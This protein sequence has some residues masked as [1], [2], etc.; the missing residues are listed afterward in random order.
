MGCITYSKL[1]NIKSSILIAY[2]ICAI[3]LLKRGTTVSLPYKKKFIDFIEKVQ[4]NST[5][6]VA[7]R[8]TG[9]GYQ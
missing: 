9:L 3:P 2:E 1:P 8:W 5:R 6:K 7:T 4:N